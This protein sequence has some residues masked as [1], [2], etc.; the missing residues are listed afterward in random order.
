MPE[1]E[2]Y[3]SIHQEVAAKFKAV[4]KAEGMSAREASEAT[5]IA[6]GTWRA[7]EQGQVPRFD[8]LVKLLRFPAFRKFALWFMLDASCPQAGQVSPE[9]VRSKQ[10]DEF[11]D[12][13]LLGVVIEAV[14]TAARLHNRELPVDRKS[15]IV[16]L[17]YG[18]YWNEDHQDIDMSNVVRLVKIAA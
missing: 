16:S 13:D 14:E 11:L 1:S 7:I 15:K 17:L 8:Q 2:N 18:Q 4:R 9:N 5:G 3:E 12:L 10:Y 6:F